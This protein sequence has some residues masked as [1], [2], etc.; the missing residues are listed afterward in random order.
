MRA[1]LGKVL[2]LSPLTRMSLERIDQERE[3][4]SPAERAMQLAEEQALPQSVCEQM[5]ARER[6]DAQGDAVGHPQLS[7]ASA[8]LEMLPGTVTFSSPREMAEA[9]AWRLSPSL[10]DLVVDHET[11]HWERA[12]AFGF[13]ATLAVTVTRSS[14]GRLGY[15]PFV[16]AG[17]EKAPGESEVHF[18]RKLKEICLAPTDPSSHDEVIA[19]AQDEAIARIQREEREAPLGGRSLAA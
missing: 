1:D 9:L 10:V 4:V 17:R 11:D 13:A 5:L 18:R 6:S 8:E 2:L 14:D 7:E 12:R 16:A 19:K 3:R 15:Q